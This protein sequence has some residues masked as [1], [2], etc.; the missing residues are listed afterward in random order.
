M[1]SVGRPIPL[2]HL[3]VARRTELASQ[4][5]TAAEVEQALGVERGCP[6]P[7]AMQMACEG[8]LLAAYLPDSGGSWRFPPWQFGRDGKPVRYLA[9][10]LGSIW[11]TGE[12]LDAKGRTTGWAEIEWFIAGHALLDGRSPAELLATMP[13]QV[14]RAALAEFQ[15]EN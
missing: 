12:A 13:Y 9:D 14:L 2:E 1:R 11:G 4:W 15:S 3:A 6:A 5:P 8:R 7:S 10:I